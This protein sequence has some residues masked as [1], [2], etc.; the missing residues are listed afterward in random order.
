MPKLATL[1]AFVLF[2]ELTMGA[3]DTKIIFI[4]F[5]GIY[6]V[7]IVYAAL[8]R[9]EV[10]TSPLGRTLT[11]LN[12]SAFLAAIGFVGLQRPITGV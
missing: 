9:N 10:D 7:A 12:K 8:N 11:A 1:L 6:E 5:N 4:I 2:K 3:N